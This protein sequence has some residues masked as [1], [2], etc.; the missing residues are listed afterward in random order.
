MMFGGYTDGADFNIDRFI[1]DSDNNML[2]V[3]NSNDPQLVSV[4]GTTPSTIFRK[5]IGY[6]PRN[7]QDFAW[8]SELPSIFDEGSGGLPNSLISL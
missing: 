4:G 8:F 3:G 5:C 6:L 7:A 2:V 1:F